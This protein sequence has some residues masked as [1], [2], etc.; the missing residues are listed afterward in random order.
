MFDTEIEKSAYVLLQL[1]SVDNG[2]VLIHNKNNLDFN[3][4][5][6]FH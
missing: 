1:S 6:C 3:S 2:Y 5:K 4:V